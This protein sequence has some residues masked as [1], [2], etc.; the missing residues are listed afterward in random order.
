MQSIITIY[1]IKKGTVL[2]KLSHSIQ[3]AW[4]LT[5]Q[6]LYLRY[7]GSVLG[8]TWVFLKPLLYVTI[9]TFI[10][11]Q[12][13]V[14]RFPSEFPTHSY[15]IYLIG[16]M[17]LWNAF[18]NTVTGMSNF[19]QQYAAYLKKIPLSLFILPIFLPLTE[20][21][22]WLI[23]MIIFVTI[24]TILQHPIT[25]TWWWLIP[26]IILVL[27][28]AYG[29]GLILA[30]ANT[31]IPDVSPATH[32]LMQLVFWATPIIYVIDILPNWSQ[33]IIWIN[34]I[35]WAISSTQE[36]TVWNRTPP[37]QHLIGLLILSLILMW[38]AARVLAKAERSLRDL[39]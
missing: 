26:V 31:F 16:G 21:I 38:A 39:L 2:F 23:S 30:I 12:F 3:S 33:T 29:L 1:L 22:I 27:I 32:I 36:I 37:I 35:T 17:L 13:M 7:K 28:F 18:S 5:K 20:L 9:F 15:V 19:Y 8:A 10:F 24:S 25:S 14:I 11:S 34:P 4:L 6:H